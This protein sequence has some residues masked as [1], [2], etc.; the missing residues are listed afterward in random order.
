[1]L[2]LTVD[3]DFLAIPCLNLNLASVNSTLKGLI[4]V[5]EEVGLVLVEAHRLQ[6]AL[7]VPVLSRRGME[8]RHAHHG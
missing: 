5:L 8:N 3:H 7:L 4:I 6:L 2:L 1:M